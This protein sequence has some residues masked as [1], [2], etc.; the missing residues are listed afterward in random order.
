MTPN[1]PYKG[2][3]SYDRNDQGNF[4]GRD[5]EKELLI[6]QILTHKITLLYAATGVGKSSLLSAA[7]IP[8]L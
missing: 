8:E 4:F 5:H 1:S 6:S 2:L 3:M 7:V